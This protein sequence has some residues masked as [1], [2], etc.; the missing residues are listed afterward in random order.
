MSLCQERI[1]AKKALAGTL[2][3]LSIAENAKKGERRF[4]H[5]LAFDFDQQFCHYSQLL[6]ITAQYIIEVQ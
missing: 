6:R 1:T 5:V 2:L 4:S 3:N